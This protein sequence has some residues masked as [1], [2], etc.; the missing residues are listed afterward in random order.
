MPRRA[1]RLLLRLLLGVLCGLTIVV[2]L[3]ALRRLHLYEDAFGL[4]RLRLTAAAF[5]LWLGGLF[6]LLVAAGLVRTLRRRLARI[7]PA[8]T[9]AAILAFSLANPDGMVAGRNVDHWRDTGRL[10]LAYLRGLS[11]DAVPALAELPPSLRRPALAAA[12]ARLG[13]DEPWSSYNLARERARA[14]LDALSQDG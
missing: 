10:D 12:A 3:S 8:G 4:T 11:A 5:A 6:V 9:A 7:A 2:L 13:P 14:V 1:H